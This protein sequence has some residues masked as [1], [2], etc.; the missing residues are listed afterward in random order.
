MEMLLT[1][2][3]PRIFTKKRDSQLSF[4]FDGDNVSSIVYNAI[5]E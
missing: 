2:L 4:I 5:T 1:Q 3:R